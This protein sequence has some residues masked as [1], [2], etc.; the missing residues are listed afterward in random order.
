MR[1]EYS[2]SSTSTTTASSIPPLGDRRVLQRAGRLE[3]QVVAVERDVE[4]AV[5]HRDPGEFG[6]VAGEPGGQRD[7]AGRD[8]QQHHVRRVGAVQ[9]RL[10]DDLVR[11]ARDG[12]TYVCGGHQ[13]PVR[14]GGSHE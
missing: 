2:T 5:R 7:A 6:D 14:A 10:L 12:P 1:P 8:A 11:D 13:F 3:V 9:C 4:S